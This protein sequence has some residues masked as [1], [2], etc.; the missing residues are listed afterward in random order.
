MQLEDPVLLIKLFSLFVVDCGH[1]LKHISTVLVMLLIAHFLDFVVLDHLFVLKLHISRFN[2]WP[3]CVI[4][5][6][7]KLL[8]LFFQ[9]QYVLLV[10]FLF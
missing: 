9:P 5:I 4:I 3:V 1:L 7:E 8:I 2:V 10:F 6:L